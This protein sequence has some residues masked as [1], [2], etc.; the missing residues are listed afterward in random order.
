MSVQTTRRN[1]TLSIGATA[2]L[3]ACTSD[4]E[5]GENPT[6][7]GGGSPSTE[8]GPEP[9]TPWVPSGSEDPASF[10]TG[11]QL[12][13][14]TATSV[15]ASVRTT[16][17]TLS[18]T[19][20]VGVADGWEEVTTVTGLSPDNGVLQ[21]EIADL[22]ADHTYGVVFHVE[23]G[24]Q[25]SAPAR[26]RSALEEGASRMIRF[27]AVSCLGGNEPWTSLSH[28][29]AERF[30]F[31]LMLG[32]TIYADQTPNT[33]QYETKWEH[34]LGVQGL[35]DLAA[36]TSFIG[37]WDDHEVD[38]NWSWT[39][40]GIE[41]RVA[42]G[43]A[44]FQRGMPQR[45]GPTGGIWRKLSWGSAIDL[46]VLD[47]RS[48]RRDGNYL[49]PEQLSWLQSE[50]TASTARFKIILNP[51][52]IIDFTGTAVGDIQSADRWQGFA[53]Q[54]DAIV[55]HIDAS[56]EGVL[57]VSGDFHVG[58][59]GF[60]SPSGSPGDTQYEVLAGPGGSPINVG[61][62]LFNPEPARFPAVVKTWNYTLFEADPDTGS[63]RVVF[64]GDDGDTLQE[65]TLQL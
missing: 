50:L 18:M 39:A 38:N 56:I 60:V 14:A 12:G 45:S 43:L 6:G 61:A 15:I 22:V 63:V 44:A 35:R 32:D 29:S 36:S 25:R 27:G 4:D 51:V 21:L 55:S 57:W 11:V 9:S 30:D 10:P 52:P 19:L 46:F 17:Q 7:G 64:V 49:A 53:A 48:E 2:I 5:T 47:A 26:F 58:G 41:A 28:A 8:P 23:G 33:F 16:A 62:S 65:L 34:A 59:V 13:D 24:D 1:F 31:F 3:A 37:T 40:P 42:E 54:R 20:A